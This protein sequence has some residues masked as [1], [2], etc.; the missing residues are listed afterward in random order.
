M[1]YAQT[2]MSTAAIVEPKAKLI[3]QPCVKRASLPAVS[4]GLEIVDLRGNGSVVW[5]VSTATKR[6]THKRLR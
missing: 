4:K 2:I 5:P 3:R 1:D 6:S